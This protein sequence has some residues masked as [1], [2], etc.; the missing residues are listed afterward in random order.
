M[1]DI[2]ISHFNVNGV[3][4]AFYSSK[5][6]NSFKVLMNHEG[7]YSNYKEDH[8]GETKYGITQSELTRVFKKLSLPDNVKDLSEEDAKKYY[9]SEWWDKFN[10]EKIDSEYIAIKTLD[11]AVN[12]GAHQAHEILQIAIN[13]CGHKIPVDGVIGGKTLGSINLII[14]NNKGGDLKEE[15]IEEQS[16]FYLNLVKHKPQ[17]KKFTKGWLKRAAY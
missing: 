8:G 1:R 11:M 7:G 6:E 9:K 15:I 17:L 13:H 5:F 16:N 4:M 12:M 2:Y 10:Y 3:S 14:K